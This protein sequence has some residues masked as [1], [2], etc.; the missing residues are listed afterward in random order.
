MELETK[1]ILQSCFTQFYGD[2]INVR[3]LKS[4]ERSP[5]I[6]RKWEFEKKKKKLFAS[7]SNRACLNDFWG[8]G[9]GIRW[10]CF[11][12][13]QDLKKTSVRLLIRQCRR[14]GQEGKTKREVVADFVIFPTR[15]LGASGF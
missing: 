12:S 10:G 13:T 5:H 14:R 1:Q 6:L 11:K 9:E 7:M 15:I 2:N 3:H 8:I 4:V